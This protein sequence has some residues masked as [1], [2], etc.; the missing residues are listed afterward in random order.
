MSRKIFIIRQ[1]VDMV[2][3]NDVGEQATRLRRQQQQPQIGE[4]IWYGCVAAGSNRKKTRINNKNIEIIVF[5]YYMFA[6]SSFSPLSYQ[7]EI[8]ESR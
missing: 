3:C 7:A 8:Y 6:G 2:D 4:T 1:N 5:G